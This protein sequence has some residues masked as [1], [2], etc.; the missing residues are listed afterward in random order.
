MSS[1][2]AEPSS[3]KEERRCIL[4]DPVRLKEAAKPLEKRHRLERI[5]RGFCICVAVSSVGI[6]LFLI[7]ALVV[8]GVAGIDMTLLSAP[9]SPHPEEAGM[10][11]AI[12]GTVWL[13]VLTAF[14][15]L[16]LGVGTAIML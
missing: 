15:A 10:F 6:L 7:S 1:M 3:P 12:M 2:L 9:P 5:F 16:P 4:H 13:L 8:Q 11:P 14:F